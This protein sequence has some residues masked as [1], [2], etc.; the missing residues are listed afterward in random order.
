MASSHEKGYLAKVTKQLVAF[1]ATLRRLFM[2]KRY[3]ALEVGLRVIGDDALDEVTHGRKHLTISEECRIG[4]RLFI[5][6][7]A[8]N[9]GSQA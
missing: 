2:K 9:T 5:E 4:F 8:E 6:L 1:T 3:K 7:K